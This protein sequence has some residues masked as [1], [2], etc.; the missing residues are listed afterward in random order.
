M[1][2]KNYSM[3][4]LRE[5]KSWLRREKMQTKKSQQRVDHQKCH[6]W[7]IKLLVARTSLMP[8]MQMQNSVERRRRNK[9]IMRNTKNTQQQ[10][11]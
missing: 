2:M 6:P 10:Q 7:L 4:L 9:Q 5:K 3:M 11:Y 8:C 1:F